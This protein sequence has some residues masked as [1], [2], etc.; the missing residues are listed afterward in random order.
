MDLTIPVYIL[1]KPEILPGREKYE[2]AILSYFTCRVSIHEM[3]RFIPSI[4]FNR[5][6]LRQFTIT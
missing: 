2:S 1:D 5:Y 3:S 6:L 4:T